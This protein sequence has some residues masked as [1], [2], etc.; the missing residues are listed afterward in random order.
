MVG[1]LDTTPISNKNL[2][3]KRVF[4]VAGSSIGLVLTW[5]IV[6]LGYIVSTLDTGENGFFVQ[7]RIGCHGRKFKVIKLR[8]MKLNPD[9]NTNVTTLNDQ[10]VTMAGRILR[11]AKIDELPQLVNILIGDMSFVGPRPDVPGFADRLEGAE[12]LILSVRP[13]L[14][15]PATLKYKNEE[16]LLAGKADPEEYNKRVI[17]P[18]K[19]RINL[20]YIQNYSFFKD[21]EYILKTICVR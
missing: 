3:L 1:L 9:I 10:R 13:G 19:V 16:E 6:L 5:W 14:T 4:D 17:Y 20:E 21:M 7:E 2:F 15:G 12:R 11:S 8:T 18:D